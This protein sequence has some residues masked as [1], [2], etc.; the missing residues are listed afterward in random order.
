MWIERIA[1]ELVVAKSTLLEIIRAEMLG[2]GFGIEACD[3]LFSILP[4]SL[5]RC[6]CFLDRLTGLWRYE[7]G[8]PHRVGG[9]LIWGVHMWPEVSVLVDVL[10]CAR[11][12]LSSERLGGYLML[13]ADLRKH[14]DHLAEMYP[15]LRVDPSVDAEHEVAGLG[16]GNL[17]TGRL[18]TNVFCSM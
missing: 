13:L 12:R 9:K 5:A 6:E 10:E 7:L 8:E 11:H 2:R 3:A 18:L 15:M 17:S 4:S 14:Q 1:P 16:V